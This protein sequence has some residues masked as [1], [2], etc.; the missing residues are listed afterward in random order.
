MP[1]IPT[2]AT[3]YI[4][5]HCSFCGADGSEELEGDEFVGHTFGCYDFR[6]PEC[7]KMLSE[8]EDLDELDDGN[9][10]DEEDEKDG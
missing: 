4:S 10:Q 7:G 2:S 9:E 5:F 6:C 1:Y 3:V 8:S